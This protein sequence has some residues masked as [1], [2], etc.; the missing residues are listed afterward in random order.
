MNK[1]LAMTTMLVLLIAAV[2]NLDATGKL[3][4][5]NMLPVKKNLAIPLMDVNT[6]LRNVMIMILALLILVI[7]KLILVS[8]HQLIVTIMTNVPVT[9]VL[10]DYVTLLKRTVTIMMHVL[11][12]TATLHLENA[13][14]LPLN[15]TITTYVL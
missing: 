12:N 13:S 1:F 2:L 10:K 3:L 9:S 14:L 6:L 5:V 4:S 11:I 7:V 8:I 15:V